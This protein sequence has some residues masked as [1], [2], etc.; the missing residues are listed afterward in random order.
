MKHL[1][2]VLATLLIAT[3]S[4]AETV[5]RCGPEGREYSATP[6][7]DGKTLQLDD[8]RTPAQQRDAKAAAR[9][10]A[11]LAEQMTR[12]RK[13]QEAAAVKTAARIGPSPAPAASSAAHGKNK[14]KKQK[15]KSDRSSDLTPP[16]RGSGSGS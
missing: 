12:E 8:S 16:L 13:T 3:P 2:L 5:Y 10:E 4:V 15:V 6:C 7:S 1:P 9:R 14:K 11:K